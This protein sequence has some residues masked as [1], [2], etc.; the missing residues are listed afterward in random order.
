[1]ESKSG[2]GFHYAKN[3]AQSAPGKFLMAVALIFSL[4]SIPLL[5]RA[6]GANGHSQSEKRTLTGNWLVTVTRVNPP[7][8]LPPTF[9]SLMTCFEDGNVSE[10][11]NTPS[12]RSTG[13]GDW[14]RIGHHQFTRLTNYFRFDATRNYLGMGVITATITLSNDGSEFQANAAVQSFDLS[15]N[16]LSTLQSTEF[17]QRL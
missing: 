12:I 11:S 9:L 17:G 8:T 5:T 16:L 3:F 6:D 14:E 10:E 4:V 15:G 7:P 1:M 2:R 13:H